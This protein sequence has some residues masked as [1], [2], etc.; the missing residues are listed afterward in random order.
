MLKEFSEI[1]TGTARI[2]IG[3]YFFEKLSQYLDLIKFRG[4]FRVTNLAWKNEPPNSSSFRD[5]IFFK[6]LSSHSKRIFF[7]DDY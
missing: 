5:R 3:I 2:S 1:W 4:Q 7:A 6:I